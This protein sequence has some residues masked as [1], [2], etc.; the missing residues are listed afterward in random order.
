MSQNKLRLLVRVVQYTQSESIRQQPQTNRLTLTSRFKSEK[1]SCYRCFTGVDF[2]FWT[3]REWSR[4]VNNLD[5]R[6]DSLWVYWTW[7]I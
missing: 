3:R 5:S 6:I 1:S 2:R 4:I 7:M